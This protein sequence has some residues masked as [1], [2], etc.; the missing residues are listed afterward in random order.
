MSLTLNKNYTSVILPVLHGVASV[1]LTASRVII[2]C[3]AAGCERSPLTNDVNA[4]EVMVDAVRR[5]FLFCYHLHVGH[6]G[7]GVD[8]FHARSLK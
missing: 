4:G 7:L 6:A 2:C 1:W 3:T 5:A 8:K